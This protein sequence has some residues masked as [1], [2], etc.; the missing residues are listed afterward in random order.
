MPQDTKK[1][2]ACALDVGSDVPFFL[3][4]EPYWMGG[5]GDVFERKAQIEHRAYTL[6]IPNFVC[7]TKS[8]YS[9]IRLTCASVSDRIYNGLEDNAAME[10]LFRND[11]ENAAARVYPVIGRLI[12][13]LRPLG[14]RMT[15]SGSAFFGPLRSDWLQNPPRFLTRGRVFLVETCAGIRWF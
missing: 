15:G 8:V 5:I 11:L 14:F 9:V 2:I 4:C 1:D 13:I 10:E 3:R 12:R 7:S 6:V